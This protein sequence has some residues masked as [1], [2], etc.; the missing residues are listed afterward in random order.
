[1]TIS[2][3]DEAKLIDREHFGRS[4][5]V[6]KGAR[7]PNK[8]PLEN[9]ND[10]TQKLILE[11]PENEKFVR[12]EMATDKVPKGAQD[13]EEVETSANTYKETEARTEPTNAHGSINSSYNFNEENIPR[14]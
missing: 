5:K 9:F 11:V 2:S 6:P 14:E 8:N 10:S 7:D 3:C 12:P 4:V 1:M 13:P